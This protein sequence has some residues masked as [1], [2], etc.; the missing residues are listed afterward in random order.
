SLHGATELQCPKNYS[1]N[2]L[3]KATKGFQEDNK[4]GEGGFGDVYKG[5]VKDGN[6]VP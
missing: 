1:F 5:I 3:K 4:L 6:I 2:D